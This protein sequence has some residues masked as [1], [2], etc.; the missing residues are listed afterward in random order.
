MLTS[1]ESLSLGVITMGAH[2]SD[3]DLVLVIRVCVF[4]IK[5]LTPFGCLK[6]C[7]LLFQ[8]ARW[9]TKYRSLI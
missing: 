7:F 3:G 1:S 5:H 6:F 9:L 8:F 4:G 2:S